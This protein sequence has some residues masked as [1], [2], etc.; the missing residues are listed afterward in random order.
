ME[1]VDAPP[2]ALVALEAL[3]EMELRIDDAP[4][5]IELI[6]PEAEEATLEAPAEAEEATA[7]A[8]EDAPLKAD[9]A[10]AEAPPA[11]KMVVDPMVEVSTELPEVIRVTMAEVETADEDS[12]PAPAA[13]KMVVDPT[14]EVSTELPE[15][16]RVTIAEVVTAEEDA[17]APAP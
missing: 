2:A 8:S 13:P 9:E 6:A 16:I 10:D 1:V 12:L 11:P 3:L 15:V 4:P 17:A 5:V 7:E 14:V